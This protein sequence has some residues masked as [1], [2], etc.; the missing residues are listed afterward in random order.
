MKSPRAAD[1]DFNKIEILSKIQKATQDANELMRQNYL[2]DIWRFE[3]LHK[4]AEAPAYVHR[5]KGH[6]VKHIQTIGE[7]I[8][9]MNNKEDNIDVFSQESPNVMKTLNI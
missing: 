4:E 8:L 6:E 1:I 2:R 9:L 5:I 7:N 3:D